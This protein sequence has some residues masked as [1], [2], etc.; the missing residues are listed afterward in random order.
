MDWWIFIY[1]SQRWS[2]VL[3]LWY[4]GY[5]VQGLQSEA[6]LRDRTWL[7]IQK[8]VWWRAYKGVGGMLAKL[9]TQQGLFTKLC[10]PRNA[11]VETSYVLP[12]EKWTDSEFIKEC[13]VDFSALICLEKREHM[14]TFT[15]PD[16]LQQRKFGASAEEQSGKLWL[17]FSGFGWKLWYT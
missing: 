9:Q 13:L 2:R 16:A 3:S 5:C 1:R 12:L 4:T 15:S 10:T 8:P 6:R 11:A 14:N 17:L 7:E